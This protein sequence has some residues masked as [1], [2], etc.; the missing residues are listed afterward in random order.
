EHGVRRRG[1]LS[2][3]PF[4]DGGVEAPEVDRVLHVPVAIEGREIWIVPVE[5]ATHRPSDAEG[6]ARGPVV[7][8]PLVLRLAPSEFTPGEDHHA[9]LGVAVGSLD[10]RE[11]V[12]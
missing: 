9:L 8:A 12:V 7:R 4:E 2:E 5:A 10:A 11:I 3:P 1:I 6:E